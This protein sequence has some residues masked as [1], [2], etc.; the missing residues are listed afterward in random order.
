LTAGA[1]IPNAKGARV[2]FLFCSSFCEYRNQRVGGNEDARHSGRQKSSPTVAAGHRTG[3]ASVDMN[4]TR[5][6]LLINR[7][8]DNLGTETHFNGSRINQA[9]SGHAP[10]QWTF[11]AHGERE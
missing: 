5:L 7:M 8:T 10:A 11:V 4:K 3:Y 1:N 6:Q 9:F 2:S